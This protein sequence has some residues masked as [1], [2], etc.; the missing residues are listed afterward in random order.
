M[1]FLLLRQVEREHK[2]SFSIVRRGSEG[3][4]AA[5]LPAAFQH[6]RRVCVAIASD[7]RSSAKIDHSADQHV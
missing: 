7:L 4:K 3:A 2:G 6:E 5:L 1:P